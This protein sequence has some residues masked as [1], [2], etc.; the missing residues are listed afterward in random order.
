MV[1]GCSG[2]ARHYY[3]NRYYF[4]FLQLLR[5]FSSLRSF[6]S[7][8][9][10]TIDTITSY[11]RLPH[12]EIHGS[13]LI[14]SSRSVSPLIASFISSWCLGI[15]CALL[16]PLMFRIN[17]YYL[18]NFQRICVLTKPITLVGLN[19]LEPPTSRLSGVCS[20]QLSYRP[21]VK[22]RRKT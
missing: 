5:Y 11:S 18:P 22:S 3:R 21:F 10:L 13:T 14:Y 12:S 6:Q 20:N 19:G 15:H 9:C 17:N 1:S 4:L 7:V 2:F 16:F 8:S